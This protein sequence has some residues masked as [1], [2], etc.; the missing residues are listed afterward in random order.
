MPIH[1]PDAPAGAFDNL[2]AALSRPSLH[3][4]LATVAPALAAAPPG[5]PLAVAPVLSFGVYV[6]GLDKVAAG[7]SPSGAKLVNWRY[8]LP[9]AGNKLLEAEMSV[10]PAAGTQTFAAF[11]DGPFAAAVKAIV[12]QEQTIAGDYDLAALHIAAMH[13][14]AVWLRGRNGLADILIP[15]APTHPALTP[16]RHY[17][18]NQFI[19]A[20]RPEAEAALAD[21]DP[22]KGEA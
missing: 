7:A 16:G 18:A 13:V 21:D 17:S 4:Y 15:V 14:L 2:A 10:D 8:L 12:D 19:Q 3:A 11:T 6:M 1:I 5:A 9:G 22:G 20:L